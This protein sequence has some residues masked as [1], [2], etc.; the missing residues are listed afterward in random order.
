MK[1]AL[2]IVGVVLLIL[3]LAIII[4][5]IAFKGKIVA[6]VKSEI[7]N[8]INAKVD[9]TDFDLSL[10]KHFP[11]FTLSMEGL[12]V[13]GVNEFN[14][15]TLAAIKQLDVTVDV[16]SVIKGSQIVI[17]GISLDNPNINLLVLKNGKA[18]WDIAKPS[19]PSAPSGESSGFKASLEKYSITDGNILYDDASMGFRMVMVDLDHSGNGDFTQDLFILNTKTSIASTNMWYGGVKYLHQVVTELKADLEMDMKNMKFTFKDNELVLNGLGLGFN[20]W[21]AMPADDIKM[22]MTFNAKQSEFKNFLS[23]V[24]GI[25][26][27]EFKDLKSSG[28]LAF[29]GFAK[30]TYNDKTMPGFGITL[31][32]NNGMFQYPSLPTAVNHVNVD[33]AILNPDGVPDHTNIDLSKMH[34]EIGAEPF[35]A[36]LKV[37]TPVSNA[38]MDGMIKGKVNLAN[39]SKIVPLE[40]GTSIRGNMDADLSFKGRMSA[41]ELKQYDSFYAAGNFNLSDFNYTSNDYKQGFDLSQLNLTFNPKNIS[42]NKLIARMGKSDFNATGTV[43]NALPYFIKNEKLSGTLNLISNNIDLNEFAGDKTASSTTAA[44]D[45]TPSTLVVIPNNIDFTINTNINKL[46]KDNIVLQNIKGT[47]S[48]RNSVADMSNLSFNTLGGAVTISGSYAAPTAKEADMKLSMSIKDCDIQQ[49]VKTFNTVKKMAPIAEQC[50]GVYSSSFTL[51]GKLDSKMEPVMNTL[52][53][54]GKLQT[55][56]VTITNFTPLVK[57]ADAL[58][59]DQLKSVKP[60]NVDLSFEFLDG[61]IY[62]KPFETTLGGYKTKIEGSNGF[63][64]TIDYTVK[65]DLPTAKLPGAATG[66]ITGLIG[67]ANAKGAKLSMG[68][69]VSVNVLL[70]GTVTNPTVK[71]GL[72]EA[73]GAIVDDIKAKAKEEFDKKKKEL[74]D[75]AKAE[76]DRLKKEA[77]DKA[78]SEVDK[79]KKEAEDK[80]K[81]AADKA[82]KDAEQKAKDKLKGFLK[83]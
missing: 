34:L 59:M 58:K 45:T 74:E 62:I 10:I 52:N 38:D 8:N 35:D 70:G 44:A 18:N 79:A 66:V 27:K 14:G 4:L 20:G 25:Y 56:N 3:L 15:D 42:L 82:K 30:G 12:S 36:R 32:I 77:E 48:I 65:L 21:L 50:N 5:P 81:A 67:Q 69:N 47:V 9:F 2:K 1:K 49:T 60:S 24:P 57:L 80:M 39:I 31:N 19:E 54:N 55:T 83:K 46:T 53:G 11:N 7:N 73:T 43:D 23:L 71:T 78:K 6:K 16:M 17:K 26:S 33:L 76:G 22:D 63:D 68:D 28:T 29:K 40:K 64:Q 41:I 61:R 13:V 37:R 75:K 51:N 72:K